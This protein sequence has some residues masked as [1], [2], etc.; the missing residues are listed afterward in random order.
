MSNKT[1]SFYNVLNILCI[2]FSCLCALGVIFVSCIN[3]YP[4]QSYLK[5]MRDIIQDLGPGASFAIV[6]A[7]PVLILWF[8]INI[9][10]FIFYV[11]PIISLICAAASSCYAI[12]HKTTKDIQIFSI[13]AFVIMAL[14]IWLKVDGIHYTKYMGFNIT[15]FAIIVVV[16]MLYYFKAIYELII[17]INNKTRGKK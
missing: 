12:K 5:M 16:I 8:F 15:F 7:I 2:I 13:I 4:Y 9:I 14:Y 10:I 1:N 11:L 6:C 17:N 3:G